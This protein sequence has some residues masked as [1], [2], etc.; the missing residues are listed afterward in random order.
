TPGSMA[1]FRPSPHPIQ[2]PR[3]I[4]VDIA[5]DEATILAAMKQKC[6]YN[7]G[8]AKKKGVCVR[9]SADLATFYA[10]MQMTGDRDGFGVH[11]PEYYE[12]AYRLFHERGNCELLLAERGGKPLA[13][14]MVF[15]LGRRAWYLFGAS[16]DEGRNLMPA[17]LLQWE[18]IRWAKSR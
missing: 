18:A 17:Y 11:A 15:A 8:L 10:L 7:I 6:R 4:L 13:A 9:P 12:T 2:P 14:L 5:G 3:T 1:G 16:S